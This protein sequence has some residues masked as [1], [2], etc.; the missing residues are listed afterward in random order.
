MC[1]L[2]SHWL[3]LLVSLLGSL[4]S[5]SVPLLSYYSSQQPRD[6]SVFCNSGLF[7]GNT[8][9]KFAEPEVLILFCRQG[10]SLSHVQICC[11]SCRAVFVNLAASYW[12]MTNRQIHLDFSSTLVKLLFNSG[13]CQFFS[14][15]LFS[16]FPF[17]D[18]RYYYYYN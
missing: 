12:G 15:V 10:N 11:W 5:I 1:V 3:Q 9:G 7:V 17:F 13:L 4:F 18:Q 14:V 8:N 6:L 2:P 16:F